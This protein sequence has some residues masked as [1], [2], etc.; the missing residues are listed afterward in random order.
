MMDAKACK[1]A[2]GAWNSKRKECSP[3]GNWKEERKN[4]WWD[5]SGRLAKQV[6]IK[7]VEKPRKYRKYQVFYGLEEKFPRYMGSRDAEADARQLAFRV[8]KE[9]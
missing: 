5:T 4:N 6:F 3:Y 7:H 2:G 8:M 9:H 1:K